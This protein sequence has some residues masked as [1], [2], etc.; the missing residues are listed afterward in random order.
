MAQ[1]TRQQIQTMFDLIE[2]L[3]ERKYLPG[4][5][6]ISDDRITDALRT[7]VEPNGLMDATIAKVLRPDMSGEEFEAVAMLDEEASYGLFDTYRAIMMPSDYDVSHAIACAFKQDIPRL[8]SDFALQIH[9]T[10]DRAGAYRIAAT[11]SYM[12]GDPA[13]R[14]K[15]FADQLYRVKPEDEM[16]RTLSVALIHGIEP[17]R[18]GGVRQ[19]WNVAAYDDEGDVVSEGVVVMRIVPLARL[20]EQERVQTQR[21]QTDAGEGLAAE[22]MNRVAAR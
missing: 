10:S 16:L 4:E 3:K 11:V 1:T 14:C 20:A 12:E 15:H 6:K 19:F 9:P 5:S 7:M 18:T 8:F 22:A 13:A 21:E 2:T 17:A